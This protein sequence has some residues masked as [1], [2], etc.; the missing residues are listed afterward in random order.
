[1]GQTFVTTIPA[2]SAVDFLERLRARDIDVSAAMPG[3]YDRR[4]VC[5]RGGRVLQIELYE[6]ER[7][8]HETL[9]VMAYPPSS[10]RPWRWARDCR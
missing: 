1:M 5:E 3:T 10:G 6:H 2:G 8:P 4:H 9:V 7:S